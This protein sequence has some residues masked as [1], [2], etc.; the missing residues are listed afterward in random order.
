MG[1]KKEV[2][3][4]S[5]STLKVTREQNRMLTVRDTLQQRIKTI[6]K[7]ILNV[8]DDERLLLK[9]QQKLLEKARDEAAG[10]A[11]EYSRIR[12]ESEAADKATRGF[13]VLSD[14]AESIPG[15]RKM[16]GPFKEAESAARAAALKGKKGFDVLK[17]GFSGLGAVIKKVPLIAIFST[18]YKI[19]KF[20]VDAMFKVDE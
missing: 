13:S 6:Q 17:A 10:L 12:E 1:E 15:L 14:L 5:K 11:K 7:N 4:I 16:A 18:L 20:F 8:S 2:K 3:W 19:G 9:I